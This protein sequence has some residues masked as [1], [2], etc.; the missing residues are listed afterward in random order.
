MTH[1]TSSERLQAAAL[2]HVREQAARPVACLAAVQQHVRGP[3]TW[4]AR[5]TSE[6]AA[7]ARTAKL[8]EKMKAAILAA[9]KRMFAALHSTRHC[10]RVSVT[11]L[12][13]VKGDSAPAEVHGCRGLPANLM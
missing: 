9:S 8:S 5:S 3:H 2:Q 4:L 12:D 11:S 7:L 10:Q 6:S 1:V 13:A